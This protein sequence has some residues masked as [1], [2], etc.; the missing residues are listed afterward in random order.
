MFAVISDGNHQE[1]GA[2]TS[3]TN[4]TLVDSS[5][6]WATNSLAGKYVVVVDGAA[7]GESRKILSNTS[8]TLTVVAW[9]INPSV[10]SIYRICDKVYRYWQNNI[11][12]LQDRE[13]L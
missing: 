12:F 11:S 4:T 3:S 9:Y 5:K 10:T 1:Q 6:N 7:V 8:N 2:V 13:E